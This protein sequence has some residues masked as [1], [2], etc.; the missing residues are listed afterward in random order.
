MLN[1]LLCKSTSKNGD[2]VIIRFTLHSLTEVNF[3]PCADKPTTRENS[4]KKTY[5]L[6]LVMSVLGLQINHRRHF[7]IQMCESQTHVEVF[8]LH[9]CC[10]PTGPNLSLKTKC[11]LLLFVISE[12]VFLK[13][14]I[15]FIKYFLRIT[16]SVQKRRYWRYSTLEDNP[17]L[18]GIVLVFIT[19]SV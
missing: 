5:W 17:I 11:Q 9:Y 19:K 14:N 16:Y 13:F 4:T 10:L 6:K 18:R 2:V 7:I 1:T 8:F 12:V 15:F 3:S